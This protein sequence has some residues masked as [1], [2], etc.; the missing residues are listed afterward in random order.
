MIIPPMLLVSDGEERFEDVQHVLEHAR[1]PSRKCEENLA[2][3]RAQ[4]ASIRHGASRLEDLAGTI[5]TKDFLRL[6]ETVRARAADSARRAV[7]T[8]GV[9]Q[10]TVEQHLDDGT[11]IRLELSSDGE[12]MKLDFSGTSPRHD[13]NFN[14]P[15]AITLGATVYLMRLLANEPLPMNEGLLDPVEIHVPDCFLNPKF[16]GDA[17]RDPAVCAGNTETS[18]RVTDTLLLAFELAAC[19]QG[20]MN[21]LLFGDDSFGYYETIAGGSGATAHAAGTDAVH[22]HMT[23]TRITDPETLEARYPVALER[24]EI[25]RG[26]GGEGR[27]PG[28]HGVIRSLRART[29]LEFSFIGQHRKESPYGLNGGHAG[30]IGRQYIDRADG[31]RIELSGSE[32]FRLEAGDVI[33]IETPGGG[34]WGA[35]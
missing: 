4:L 7:R 8:M 29:T 31:E 23:N 10:K 20:T 33:T 9:L 22:T 14:A 16:T 12:T 17:A 28:G 5:G 30:L 21:N 27:N 34:G 3:L 25:R 26:S 24:F 1:F 32:E 35:P 2:D 15:I 18:Q 19:S 11:T 13:A 6:S